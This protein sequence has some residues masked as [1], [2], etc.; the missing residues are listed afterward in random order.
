[1]K[2]GITKISYLIWIIAIG[3]FVGS[4]MHYHSESLHC[5]DHAEEQ[6]YTENEQL[7]PIGIVK[8]SQLSTTVDTI[9]TIFTEIGLLSQPLY[10]IQAESFFNYKKNR[11]PPSLV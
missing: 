6:H 9:E 7:C 5:L 1:M 2:R 3:G 8:K 10:L 11:A 4:T